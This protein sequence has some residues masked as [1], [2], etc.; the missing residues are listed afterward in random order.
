MV[1]LRVQLEVRAIDSELVISVQLG[2]EGVCRSPD[3][4][5]RGH[6]SIHAVVDGGAVKGAVHAGLRRWVV[7]VGVGCE[8]DIPQAVDEMDLWSPDVGT[9]GLTGRW[10]PQLLRVSVVPVGQDGAT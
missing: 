9:V 8:Y 5:A 3:I 2:G 6:E 10:E 4:G 1:E 7:A